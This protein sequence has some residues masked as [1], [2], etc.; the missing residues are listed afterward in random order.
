MG[1]WYG[2]RGLTLSAVALLVLSGCMTSGTES[3]SGSGTSL[4]TGASAGTG[5][6][7]NEV[8]RFAGRT[9]GIGAEATDESRSV[10]ISALQARQSVLT[11]GGAYDTVAGAVLAA[12]SRTAEADLRAAR[13][14][15]Q[16]AS[17]NWLP[18]IG[19]NISLT[20][21]SDIV[22]TIFVEQVL[23]DHGRLKAERRFAKHDVEVAAVGLAED[24][25]ARVET[26]LSLYLDMVEARERTALDARTYKDMQHFEWVMS[27]RVK[28]G[29]SDPSDLNV[30]RAKLAEIQAGLGAAREKGQASLAELNAMASLPLGDVTGTSDVTLPGGVKPLSVLRAEAE[31]D[32]DIAQAQVDRAGL[33]PGLTASGTTGTS[34]G[35]PTV[36]AGG[37]ALIGF[38]TG[39]SLRAIEAA[40]DAADR[41]VTQAREDSDRA[42]RRLEARVGALSRQ[43]AEAASLTAQAKANLDLF[44]RQYD[45]G[46]RQ[47]MDVVGV[48]ETFAAR[49]SSAVALKYDLARARLEMARRMGVLADGGDI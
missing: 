4:G 45:A 30:L 10:I 11:G 32:R 2:T 35:G 15:A 26:A 43:S 5:A 12:N 1:Q 33:L 49:E 23:F 38:G 24:T 29:V 19:P 16:A 44:R 47:V 36:T 18:R 48:Y 13:L 3:G 21:L 17:R 9:G 22:A 41:R 37:G 40:R 39:A 8:S 28:G 20:S 7:K 31:R 46:Q 34:S 25:N 14:R 42:L 6:G 27:E